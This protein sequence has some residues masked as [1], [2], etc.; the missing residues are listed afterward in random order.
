MHHSHDEEPAGPSARDLYHVAR[1][2]SSGKE[3]ARLLVMGSFANVALGCAHAARIGALEVRDL[4]VAAAFQALKTTGLW[5]EY[6]RPLLGIAQAPSG[7]TVADMTTP[8][9]RDAYRSL[10]GALELLRL[11]CVLWVGIEHGEAAM[12]RA[13]MDL[14]MEACP[15]GTPPDTRQRAN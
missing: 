3:T 4:A 5:R 14:G 8:E 11:H 7:A 10:M 12:E 2:T 13:S 6:M 15:W 9:F 1:A